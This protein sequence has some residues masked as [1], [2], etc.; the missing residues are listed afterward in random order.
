L[1][2]R[3]ERDKQ[4]REACEYHCITYLEVPYWWQRDKESLVAIICQE[5]PDIV[6]EVPTVIPFHYPT[7]TQQQS[8]LKASID[9]I[10]RKN[11]SNYSIKDRMT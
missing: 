7:N 10:S 4:R 5:R 11:I 1:K 2:S 8:T 9:K 6:P 3:K